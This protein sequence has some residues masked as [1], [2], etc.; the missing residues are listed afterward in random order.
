MGMSQNIVAR[1]SDP[2]TSRRWHTTSILVATFLLLFQ[3]GCVLTPDISPAQTCPDG[4]AHR[5]STATPLTGE[6]EPFRL[7]SGQN[8]LPSSNSPHRALGEASQLLR[9]AAKMLDKNDR[10]AIQLILQAITILKD[11]VTRDTH[12]SVYERIS[13]QRPERLNHAPKGK[14]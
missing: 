7:Y 12:A 4:P 11:E 6:E 8:N 1:Q 10:T 14:A 2:L 13:T 5:E 3:K 9:Q